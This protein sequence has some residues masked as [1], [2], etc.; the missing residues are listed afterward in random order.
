MRRLDSDN[1]I[2]FVD[3]T[4][5]QRALEDT[6]ITFEQAMN[7]FHVSD[8]SLGVQTGVQGFLCVWNQLPYLRPMVPVISRIPGL[9]P[10][11]DVLYRVFAKYRLVL[12][13][14]QQALERI[15]KNDRDQQ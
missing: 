13:G 3:I 9:L 12:T 2:A 8:D 10:I 15:T 14:R 1:N 4:K 6:G 5:D 11:L 7:R